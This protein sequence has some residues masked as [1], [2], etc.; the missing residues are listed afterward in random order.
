MAKLLKHLG[1]GVKKTGSSG[2]HRS[3]YNAQKSNS[4]QELLPKS[5]TRYRSSSSLSTGNQEYDTH[6]L[7]LF[8]VDPTNHQRQP[9][10][11]GNNHHQRPPSYATNGRHDHRHGAGGGGG[12]GSGGSGSTRSKEGQKS[13]S[14][15]ANCNTDA[16]YTS[17]TGIESAVPEER[18]VFDSLPDASLAAAAE[19]PSQTATPVLSS[20]DSLL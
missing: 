9:Y 13:L 1:I 14:P 2:S 17:Y 20:Q 7:K 10:N 11:D 16:Y 4:V 6:S 15:K 18:E 3:D 5:P 12:G 19:S 8:P